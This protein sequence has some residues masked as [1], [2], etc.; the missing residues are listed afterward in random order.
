MYVTLSPSMIRGKNA[1]LLNWSSIRDPLV[2][3]VP[4]T[5]APAGHRYPRL[6]RTVTEYSSPL[7]FGGVGVV[8]HNHTGDSKSQ[9]R[10][11]DVLNHTGKYQNTYITDTS[12][13]IHVC[14]RYTKDSGSGCVGCGCVGCGSD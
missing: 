8:R 11:G 6:L 2:T 12:R 7:R 1:T 10:E 4:F 5:A 9:V 14:L 13:S 3:W